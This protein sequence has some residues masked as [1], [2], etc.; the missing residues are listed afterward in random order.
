MDTLLSAVL[1]SMHADMARME[2]VAMNIA[3][4][5]TPGFKRE[6]VA[7]AAFGAQLSAAATALSVHLD[8]RP[9]TLKATGQEL[10]VALSGAGWFEVA[11]PAGAAYTRLGQFHLDAQGRLVTQQGHPV[12]GVGGEIVLLQGRPVIDAAGRVF[13]ATPGAAAA[14]REAPSAQLKIVQFESG[15]PIR[16]LGEGLV[17]PQGQA[18]PAA[19]DALQVRQGFLENSN[20][21]HLHEM[22]QLLATVR[23]MES[24][25]K[26]ALGYDEMLGASI[27][28]LGEPT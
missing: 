3:N 7:A 13:E 24:L 5:Q 19:P 28:K 12:M 14:G 4:A 25:Q 11:T 9:G 1:G 8:L 27:R 18:L 10:D 22:V 26:V 17:L 23:H 6:V 15:A 2:R 21:S 16:R 20:V